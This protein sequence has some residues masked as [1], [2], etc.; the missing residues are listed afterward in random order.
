MNA[1]LYPTFEESAISRFEFIVVL[2]HVLAT[3]WKFDKIKSY[4]FHRIPFTKFLIDTSYILMKPFFPLTFS[5]IPSSLF[6]F[7]IFH[8]IFINFLLFIILIVLK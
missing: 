7:L 2:D 8:L 3:T 4:N 1:T 5:E 6:F